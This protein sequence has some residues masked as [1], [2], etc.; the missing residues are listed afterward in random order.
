MPPSPPRADNAFFAGSLP[1]L[2]RVEQIIFATLDNYRYTPTRPTRPQLKITRRVVTPQSCAQSQLATDYALTTP[3]RLAAD[4]NY[5]D[6]DLK[7]AYTTPQGARKTSPWRFP[8]KPR[9]MYT[10]TVQPTNL[11]PSEQDYLRDSLTPLWAA[12]AGQTLVFSA[13][14]TYSP[15]AYGAT[16]PIRNYVA[17]P[18]KSLLPLVTIMADGQLS[19]MMTAQATLRAFF[20]EGAT[21]DN[22]YVAAG[23]SRA[24]SYVSP[25]N[26]T[27]T[28]APGGRG[29]TALSLEFTA[30]YKI[31]RNKWPGGDRLIIDIGDT[32]LNRG[33]YSVT[34]TAVHLGYYNGVD[35]GWFVGYGAFSDNHLNNDPRTIG[36]TE[37]PHKHNLPY[38]R[39]FRRNFSRRSTNCP[40]DFCPDGT[41]N[42][43]H[44]IQSIWRDP[45]GTNHGV[46]A[47]TG[48]SRTGPNIDFIKYIFNVSA[49]CV[50][51]GY[52]VTIEWKPESGTYYVLNKLTR[53]VIPGFLVNGTPAQGQFDRYA[54]D[55]RYGGKHTFLYNPATPTPNRKE[56]VGAYFHQLRKSYARR[57]WEHFR[58]YANPFPGYL[59][60]AA[61]RNNPGGLEIPRGTLYAQDI[62]TLDNVDANRQIY[63]DHNDG[64]L[65][66]TNMMGPFSFRTD[67]YSPDIKVTL[68]GNQS[69]FYKRSLQP[70]RVSVIATVEMKR[71]HSPLNP[72]SARSGFRG[73]PTEAYIFGNEPLYVKRNKGV[74]FDRNTHSPVIF[75]EIPRFLPGH[76]V[77]YADYSFWPV[78]FIRPKLTT[79]ELYLIDY[80]PDHV[81]SNRFNKRILKLGG[82]N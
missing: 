72:C 82:F 47:N 48:Y 31:F 17:Y 77:P 61:A 34:G 79:K 12:Y 56:H 11:N 36:P 19:L 52:S 40:Y 49:T 42:I 81:N 30:A 22:A 2:N 14:K 62:K 6:I 9:F 5:Y 80:S 37:D 65:Y 60:N 7:Q 39:D 15:A 76:E 71:P 75:C 13:K 32:F 20:P 55:A 63:F 45:G 27:L 69:S 3:P 59:T 21:V 53:Y 51:N 33:N 43:Y 41:G 57:G 44:E 46:Y 74:L 68:R 23:A 78:T 58:T 29:L 4:I 64:N 35:H 73:W 10:R 18:P 1:Q 50:P 16:N 25:E 67:G 66:V 54:R 28:T 26:V 38:S 8:V 70:P 24:I